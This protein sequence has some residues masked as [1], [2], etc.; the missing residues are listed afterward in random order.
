VLVVLV[1]DQPLTPTYWTYVGDRSIPFL[2]VIEHTNFM[3][4]ED[5]GGNHIVYLGNYLAREDSLY[6]LGREE[7]FQLY[8][9][10]LKRLNPRFEPAWVREYHYHREEAAQPVVTRGYSERIPAHRTPIPRLYLANTTQIYPEDRGT[11][12]SVRLGR[13]V[14]RMVTNDLSGARTP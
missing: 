1:M 11:N 3:P 14:A 6:H 7:L 4:P 10:S 9:G 8:L 5:Y 13:E 2:G 12:Y